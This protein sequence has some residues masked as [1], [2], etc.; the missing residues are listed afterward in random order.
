[1]LGQFGKRRSEARRRYSQFVREGVGKESI[2]A[3]LKQQIYLGDEQFV[4]RMQKKAKVQGFATRRELTPLYT[5]A[6]I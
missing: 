5:A 3:G 6:H 2:W 1:L 4:K